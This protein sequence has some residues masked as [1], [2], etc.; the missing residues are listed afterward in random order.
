MQ[1]GWMHTGDKKLSAN[2]PPVI[3]ILILLCAFFPNQIGC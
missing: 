2:E 1:H 3:S